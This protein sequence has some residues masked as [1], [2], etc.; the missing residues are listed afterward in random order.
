MNKNN[1][2]KK[3][4][5]LLFCGLCVLTLSGCRSSSLATINSSSNL[6][7]QVVVGKS[8]VCQNFSFPTYAKALLKNEKSQADVDQYI[9]E[10]ETSI[11]TNVYSKMY[12]SYYVTYASNPD[13]NF[14]IRSKQVTFN[15]PKYNS[16]TD[17]I[18]FSFN[19]NSYSAWN[20]YHP[21]SAEGDDENE[22]TNL[23]LNISSSQAEFPFSQSVGSET[24]GENYAKLVDSA[25]L[26]NFSQSDISDFD[27]MTFSYDYVTPHKRLHS[28]ADEK[29]ENGGYYHHIW[30]L[31]RSNLGNEKTIEVKMV[32]AV[33]GWWYLVVLSSVVGATLIGCLIIFVTN[34]TRKKNVNKKEA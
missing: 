29:V 7:M 26:N 14:S 28:N 9:S 10:L 2:M 23:F 11:Y 15:E 19:F 12:L 13:E 25:L 4:F 17:K 31:S 8:F 5:A 21:S 24:V 22:N 1:L 6:N 3:L 33:R 34:K 27:E 20:Y 18:E 32:S 16:Q 30:T